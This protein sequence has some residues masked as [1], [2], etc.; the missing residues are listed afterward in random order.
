MPLHP[1]RVSAQPLSFWKAARPYAAAALACVVLLGATVALE[2]Q[3]RDAALARL[4]SEGAHLA[5]AA[6]QQSLE[7]IRQAELVM[8]LLPR[9]PVPAETGAVLTPATLRD[10]LRAR[11]R[12]QPALHGIAVYG[13]EGPLSAGSGAPGEPVS[14][15]G[16]DFFETQRDAS[17]D[18]LR[19][20][21]PFRAPRLGGAWVLPVSR[22]LQA[23]D[24]GFAGVATVTL[25]LDAL[26]GQLNRL[27]LPSGAVLELLNPE[28]ML[29]ARRPHVEDAVGASLHSA[30][31]GKV[32]FARAG[33]VFTAPSP[34]DG[35]ERLYSFVRDARY[36]VVALVGLPAEPVL[37]VWRAEAMQ[38]GAI[39]VALVLLVAGAGWRNARLEREQWRLART[40]QRSLE[41]REALEHALDEHVAMDLSDLDGTVLRVNQRF[42]ALSQY[43][44]AE[45]I[46][47]NLR[48]LDA[49]AHSAG[50]HQAMR[51]TLRSGGVWKGELRYRAKDGSLHWLDT[52]MLPF[53][54]DAGEPQRY[55]ALRTDVT[56]RK[57]LEAELLQARQAQAA[58]RRSD[59]WPADAD[60]TAEDAP[61]D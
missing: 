48:T 35:V 36:P 26:T 12:A 31:A 38:H 7:A 10:A 33:G 52:T 13:A 18:M 3:A 6:L 44:P 60:T 54:G 55:L 2:W 37:A 1:D 61:R 57:Q 23:P 46:G 5:T 29:L 43:A 15:R 49:G 59:P 42:C 22:R 4:E 24:G 40:L 51:H 21:A 11:A 8:D 27:R 34:V 47:Q 53:P 30:F 50:F 56:A 45:L 20:G 14:A 16:L 28:A 39:A 17:A 9:E 58:S 19:V 41:K 25:R 32:P